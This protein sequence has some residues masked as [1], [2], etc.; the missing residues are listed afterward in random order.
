[1]VIIHFYFQCVRMA[2]NNISI[3]GGLDNN[4]NNLLILAYGCRNS[5][6]ILDKFDA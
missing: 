2:M 5:V 3:S 6:P 4:K 1:M